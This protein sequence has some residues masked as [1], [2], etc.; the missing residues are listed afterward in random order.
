[1]GVACSSCK[2]CNK[3][4][5]LDSEVMLDKVKL[6][7]ILRVLIQINQEKEYFQ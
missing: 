2:S 4:V 3:E 5:E 6:H 7:R 1:M